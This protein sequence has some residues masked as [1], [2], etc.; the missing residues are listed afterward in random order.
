MLLNDKNGKF[1]CP[2]TYFFLLIG[3]SDGYSSDNMS[4]GP[5]HGK[6]NDNGTVTTHSVTV[7][8]PPLD[9][10]ETFNDPFAIPRSPNLASLSSSSEDKNIDKQVAVLPVYPNHVRTPGGGSSSVVTGKKHYV[11][12]ARSGSVQQGGLTRS[13]RKAQ[14]QRGGRIQQG[15]RKAGTRPVMDDFEWNENHRAYRE[16]PFTG[17]PGLLIEPYY[18][19][20]CLSILKLFS[21]DELIESIF[22]STNR[23][24]ELMKQVPSIKIKI[25]NN[26]RSVYNLWNDVNV[27]EKWCYTIT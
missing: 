17:T 15:I 16:F 21:T 5:D 3:T 9:D 19:T 6:R 4:V 14:R 26:P 11:P 22:D 27:D 20:C 18:R 7:D 8:D 10:D 1:Q 12:Q 25:M 23:F 24:V 13:V 2:K